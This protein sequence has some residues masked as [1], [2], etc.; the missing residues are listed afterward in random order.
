VGRNFAAGMSGGIA[1]VLNADGN[2]VYF[3][4]TSMVELSPI[5]D[6]EDQEF[7]KSM[8]TRHIEFTKSDLA[9]KILA[10]W[11]EY[12]PK[13]L[14]VM[15]LEYKRALQELKLKEIENQLENIRGENQLEVAF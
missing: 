13:F 10:S 2:F 7:V 14:K 3:C 4:N 12:M 9:R 8:L 6:H 11:H 1:Y 5:F 15:P